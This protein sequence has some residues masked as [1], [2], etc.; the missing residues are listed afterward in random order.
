MRVTKHVVWVL[1]ILLGF[2]AVAAEAAPRVPDLPLTF[3]ANAGQLDPRVKFIAR[4]S[5]YRVFLTGNEA[6]VELRDAPRPERRQLG[7]A[8][9][10]MRRQQ[11]EA[12][13]ANSSVI[14]MKLAGAR[15]EPAIVTGE[16]LAGRAHYFRGSDPASWRRDVA[17]FDRVEMKDVYPGIDLVYYGNARKQL[18]YDLVVAPRANPRAIAL[19]F[20]GADDVSIAR[21][22]DLVIRAGGR[23]LRQRRPVVYQMIGRERQAVDAWY[24]AQGQRRVGIQVASYVASLPLVIDPVLDLGANGVGVATASAVDA[25]G[26]TIL[27]GHTWETA[28]PVTDGSAFGGG[29]FDAFVVKVDASN[30]IIWATYLGGDASDFG[31]ALA[32]DGAGNAYITGETGSSDFP[33][34]AAALQAAMAGVTDAFITKLSPTGALVYSTYLG[35]D[36]LDFG[37]GI[38]VDSAANAYV[39]GATYSD[40][41]F[42]TG[43][44]PQ[45]YG[46]L[47]APDF[48]DAFVAKLS[49][50]G[51]LVYFTVIGSTDDDSANGVSSDALG[52]VNLIGD[53]YAFGGGIT[54]PVPPC[55]SGGAPFS[56]FPVTVTAV[57]PCFGGGLSDA[58]VATLDA[59]GAL[60]YGSYLGGEGDDVGLAV[61]TGSI[62]V[63]GE[64]NSEAFPV[65][66]AIQTTFGGGTDAY[67]A[68]F[69]DPTA[70]TPPTV[71]FSTYLGGSDAEFASGVAVN[72]AGQIYVAG[73]TFSTDF[74]TVNTTQTPSGGIEVTTTEGV[75]TVGEVWIATLSAITS[76]TQTSALLYSAPTT[77]PL[78]ADTISVSVTSVNGG[79]VVLGGG[80]GTTITVPIEIA[81]DVKPT[82]Q[83][84][85]KGRIPVVI[86][87]TSTFDARDLDLTTVTFGRTGE[88]TR[89]VKCAKPT[90]HNG[91]GRPDVMCDFDNPPAGFQL[92]DSAAL[93]KG[94][95]RSNPGVPLTLSGPIRT[96][97]VAAGK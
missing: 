95:L 19:E 5:G 80:A 2:A 24:V 35:G 97:P 7:R 81:L 87:S 64:T 92:G 61:A 37:Q 48:G 9:G 14:R 75:F 41:A 54:L 76:P 91:D 23:E 89:P 28:F 53:T 55:I 70:T 90:D 94:A 51:S 47:S 58:F 11:H 22:G 33:T 62:V 39:V 72:A 71:L 30:N 42:V 78:L 44:T 88:E 86:L 12:R 36:D 26:N 57:Q 4:G 73:T 67:V 16:P 43:V 93:L 52:G 66:N 15:P 65:F 31:R 8:L 85:A 60:F 21:D 27:T 84:K 63:T 74:P 18:E 20:E 10:P 50:E 83:P 3:E 34:T 40:L 77:S 1:A 96:A 17:L 45:T 25:A 38:A 46:P 32:L 59:T 29:F 56:D 6:V 79:A 69:T 82:I 49:A 68:K 13:D